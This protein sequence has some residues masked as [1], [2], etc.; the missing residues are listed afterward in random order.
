MNFDDTPEEAAYRAKISA[1]L[2]TAAAGYREPVTGGD[3]VGRAKAWQTVKY[4]AGYVGITWPKALGGQ[5]ATPMQQIIF[6]QEE[7]QRWSRAIL[8]QPCAA[9]KY[10]ASSFPNLRQGQTLRA[11]APRPSVTAMIG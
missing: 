8:S 1:W 6:N 9:M 11:S 3:G 5:G 10:G 7:S 2:S 4:S